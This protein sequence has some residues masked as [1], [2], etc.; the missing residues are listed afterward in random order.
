[1]K[2]LFPWKKNH[3]LVKGSRGSLD[4]FAATEE[5]MA[6]M[7]D[8]FADEIM[9]FHRM[10]PWMEDAEAFGPTFEV[11]Q[12]DEGFKV[13]AELPG[14]EEKDVEV[15]V[16]DD[17]LTIRGEKEEEHHKGHRKTRVSEI[18]YGSFERSFRLPEGIDREKV[19]AGFKRGVLTVQVPRTAEAQARCRRIPVSSES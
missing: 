2:G 5:R 12:S 8:A 7:L 1:M 3:E 16:D 4:P 11:T 15:W 10:S 18:R 9:P 19:G 13:R 14:M 6:S 17:M